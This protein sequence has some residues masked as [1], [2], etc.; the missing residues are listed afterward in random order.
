MW[1]VRAV[2]AFAAEIEASIA[3]VERS[4]GGRE[5]IVI[6]GSFCSE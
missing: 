1:T 3:M 5:V 6:L 4:Q 2:R